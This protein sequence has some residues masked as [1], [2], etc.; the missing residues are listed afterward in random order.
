MCQYDERTEQLWEPII[1]PPVQE[2]NLA[3]AIV[4]ASRY[5]LL[6]IPTNIITGEYDPEWAELLKYDDGSNRTVVF[7]TRE[8]AFQYGMKYIDDPWQ[9]VEL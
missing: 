1:S 6:V 8:D 4:R 3:R 5:V 7:H 9:V 2:G